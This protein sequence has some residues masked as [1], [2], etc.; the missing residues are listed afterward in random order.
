MTTF[1]CSFLSAT[2]V[3]IRINMQTHTCICNSKFGNT[4]S[5]V[6]D[7]VSLC[8]FD[9]SRT[10]YCSPV[11]PHTWG[12]IPV[13]A[14]WALA[15][16]ACACFMCCF[17][18]TLCV[19]GNLSTQLNYNSR[20][21]NRILTQKFVFCFIFILFLVFSTQFYLAWPFLQ[22]RST[23][24]FSSLL[25][26]NYLFKNL[27]GIKSSPESLDCLFPLCSY[28]PATWTVSIPP[29]DAKDLHITW[30]GLA[31]HTAWRLTHQGMRPGT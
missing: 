3:K 17:G 18:W 20:P 28:S 19:L 9:L 26:F 5:V 31:I 13:L 27:F 24:L 4:V 23:S 29:S 10:C 8:S 14:S 1:S 25:A 22:L 6:W 15:W 12:Y 2:F 21:G 30:A 11:R 16:Q 7:R